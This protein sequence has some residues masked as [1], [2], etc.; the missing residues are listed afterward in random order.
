MTRIG[1]RS[2]FV[3]SFGSKSIDVGQ[4]K[5][6]RR[7][8]AAVAEA[9]GSVEQLAAADLDGDGQI[10]GAGE[11]GALHQVLDQYNQAQAN[12]FAGGRRRAGEAEAPQAAGAVYDRLSFLAANRS[13]RGTSASGA[14]FGSM[15]DGWQP[16]AGSQPADAWTGYTFEAARWPR[17]AAAA[18]PA[19]IYQAVEAIPGVRGTTAV[20]GTLGVMVDESQPREKFSEL[21]TEVLSA[22]SESPSTNVVFMGAREALNGTFDPAESWYAKMGERGK[23]AY[24]AYMLD[25]ELKQLPGVGEA[26]WIAGCKTADGLIPPQLVVKLDP[27]APAGARQQVADLVQKSYPWIDL[28]IAQHR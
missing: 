10:A 24:A 8:K 17:Q 7:I 12:I 15:P 27:S 26:E 2:S 19:E 14:S 11:L 18:V 9:G 16:G 28:A 13:D 6:D 22:T 3:S 21:M 1:D 23:V 4:L 20:G 5:D 25:D